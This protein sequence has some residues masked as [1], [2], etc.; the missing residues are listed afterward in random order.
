MGTMVSI[1]T[2]IRVRYQ[3]TDKMGIV[4]H[5]NYLIWFEIGRTELFKKLGIS[6]AELESK[7]YFLLVTEA[8]CNYKAPATYDD[9]IEVI[10]TLSEF[11]NSR[12][13]F[14]YEVKR[15]NT[16]ITSGMTKHAFLGI[17]GKVARIPSDIIE[18]LNK[19]GVRK[20]G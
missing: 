5:S 18:A 2:K 10:T 17:N 8:H 3:E 20:N 6:Y 11:K 7:G 14:A 12:L 15:G 9:E 1:S 19:E 4:Y 16:L 13:A